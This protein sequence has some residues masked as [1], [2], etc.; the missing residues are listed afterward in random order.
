MQRHRHRDVRVR[1]HHVESGERS[2][3]RLAVDGRLRAEIA[4]TFELA[5]AA[6]AHELG[7]T[8]RTAGKLVLTVR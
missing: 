2:I 7:D 3:A 4:G 6:K 8:G 1:V 5:D